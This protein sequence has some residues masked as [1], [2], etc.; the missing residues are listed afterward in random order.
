MNQTEPAERVDLRVRTKQFAVRIIRMYGVLPK[1]AEADVIGRQVLR[2][3]TSVGANFR[4]AHR[5]RSDAEFVSKLGDCL[6]ELEETSYWL[7][8]LVDAGLVPPARVA[9]L[10]EECE[11]LIAILTT[12]SKKVKARKG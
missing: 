8:L 11:Q 5:A 2:S 6:K 4:E 9:A 10:R 1:Q 7:E 12:I 3:G